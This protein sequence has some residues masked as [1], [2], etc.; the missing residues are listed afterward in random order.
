MYNHVYTLTYIDIH[1][2]TYAHTHRY[3]IHT[4]IHKCIYLNIQFRFDVKL[5]EKILFVISPYC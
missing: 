5:F 1:A 3:D 4:Y 2:H